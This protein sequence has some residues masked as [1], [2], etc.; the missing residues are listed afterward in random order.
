MPQDVLSVGEETGQQRFERVLSTS[1]FDGL[2][3]ILERL[4]ADRSRLYAS[5]A[6]AQG[7]EDLLAR[8]G[9]QVVLTRQIHVQDCYSRLGPAGGIKAVLPY[10]D[11]PTQGSLPTLIN[12]DATVTTTAKAVSFFTGRLGELR[13]QLN[14]PA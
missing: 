9:Y 12:F 14:L 5:V 7:Y 4:S 2:K 3:A 1:P 6:G 10:Y 11:I 8:L 13:K